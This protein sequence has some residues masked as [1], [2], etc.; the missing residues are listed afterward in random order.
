[1]L[2]IGS[3]SAFNTS[4]TIMSDSGALLFLSEDMA[5]LTSFFVIMSFSIDG[6]IPVVLLEMDWKIFLS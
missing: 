3:P 1:M 5:F 4:A 6:S 2:T